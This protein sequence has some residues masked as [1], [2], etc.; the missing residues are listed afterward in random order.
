MFMLKQAAQ[1]QPR[2]QTI[3]GARFSLRR[4]TPWQGA[5]LALCRTPATLAEL[6]EATRI[7]APEL[8]GLLDAFC[9]HALL[10]RW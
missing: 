3:R 1:A 4:L 8:A 7:P 5:L 10:R 2:Y 6:E 9:A